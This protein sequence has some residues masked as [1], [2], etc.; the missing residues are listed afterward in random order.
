LVIFGAVAFCAWKTRR[1]LN[2]RHPLARLSLVW[3]FLILAQVALGA[4]TIWSRKAADIATAHVV[5]G[6]LSLVCGALLTLVSFRVLIPTRAAVAP[7]R[8]GSFA[9][10]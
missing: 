8:E 6:A 10:P 1:V 5:V 3:L 2:G 7:A 9:A 4:T